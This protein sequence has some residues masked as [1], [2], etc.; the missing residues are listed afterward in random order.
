MFL[1]PQKRHVLEENGDIEPKKSILE[2][3]LDNEE[4]DDDDEEEEGEEDRAPV[5]HKSHRETG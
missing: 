4:D 1:Y 3:D 2:D 5:K